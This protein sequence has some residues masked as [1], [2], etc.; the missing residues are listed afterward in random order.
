MRVLVAGWF[1]FEGMGATAGDLLVRDLVTDWL[2]DADRPFDVATAAPFAGGV[3]WD[4][5]E[6]EAYSHLVFVCGPFGNGAP[7]DAMLRR[8]AHCS[9]IGVDLTMLEP[10]RD[11]NPFVTL[12]ERDSDRTC[13]PDF[14]LIAP[15]SQVPVVAVSL[16]HE[17]PEYGERDRHRAANATVEEVLALRQCARLRIDTRLDVE[18]ASGLRTP[19]EVVSLLGKADAT[20]TT[21]LHGLVLSLRAGV[22]V[23][24]V[25]PVAGGGKVTRQAEAL[26]WPWCFPADADAATL[27]E[28]LDECLSVSGRRLATETRAAAQRS[29]GGI[30]A[31]FLGSLAPRAVWREGQPWSE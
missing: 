29:L 16:I 23:V 4:A 11:F 9:M 28:A 27:S 10:L 13:R 3:R 24:A 7:V 22:P 6:P 25:D 21:R 5:V 8:F 17:Q 19:H 20:L 14:A 15:V 1:S 26:G 12:L 30:R 18:N 31:E 2:V